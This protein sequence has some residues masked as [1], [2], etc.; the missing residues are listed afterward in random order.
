MHVELIE[1]IT[2]KSLHDL[3]YLRNLSL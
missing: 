2:S 3:Y 1:E